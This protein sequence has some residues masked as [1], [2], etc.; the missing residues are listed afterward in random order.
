MGICNDAV[1]IARAIKHFEQVLAKIQSLELNVS[2]GGDPAVGSV[3]AEEPVLPAVAP[4]RDTFWAAGISAVGLPAT[5]V[6]NRGA[7]RDRGLIP[8]RAKQIAHISLVPFYE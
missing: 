8:K 3:L 5:S 2:R 1:R 4:S 7:R 6:R